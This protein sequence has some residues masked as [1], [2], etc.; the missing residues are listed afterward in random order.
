MRTS[1]SL[2]QLQLF[3]DRDQNLAV[4]DLRACP[5]SNLYLGKNPGSLSGPPIWHSG[6][7][8]KVLGDPTSKF[9]KKEGR[10]ECKMLNS[11]SCLSAIDFVNGI[12]WVASRASSLKWLGRPTV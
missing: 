9:E 10:T 5:L 4:M 11:M 7:S 6:W 3:T 12:S 8:A 1:I 2:S